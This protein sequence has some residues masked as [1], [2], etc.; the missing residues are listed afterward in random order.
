MSNNE[1]SKN[2]KQ[3]EPTADDFDPQLVHEARQMLARHRAT[4][5]GDTSRDNEIA[6]RIV[7]ASRMMRDGWPQL[8]DEIR[9][10]AHLSSGDREATIVEMQRLSALQGQ[11]QSEFAFRI[12]ASAL[13]GFALALTTAE[14]T[15]QY[16]FDGIAQ[17]KRSAN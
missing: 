3:P 11:L 13:L 15:E 5:G 12:L 1:M 14:V 17:V 7:Y 6:R 8:R 2:Q 9:L 16:P 4:C 10:P